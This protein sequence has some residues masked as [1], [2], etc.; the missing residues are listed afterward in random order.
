MDR[1][2]SIIGLILILV[3]SPALFAQGFSNSISGRVTGPDNRP[4]VDL[5][6]ELLDNFGRTIARKRI[7]SG[8]FYSFDGLSTGRFTV[9][10]LTSGTDFEEEEK[11]TEIYNLTP[12]MTSDEQVDFRL[13]VRQGVVKA[14]PASLFVQE[15]PAEAKSAYEKAISDLENG[16]RE[17][18][19]AGLKRAIELFPRYFHALERLGLEY[20]KR[21]NEMELR[22]A[23]ILLEAATEVNPRGYT[24][25]FGLAY[26]LNRLK[27]YDRA[28]PAAAKAVELQPQS[29]DALTLSGSILRNNHQ[30]AESEKQLLK[31][32]EL[33]DKP[34]AELHWELALLYGNHMKQYKDAAREL[35]AYLSVKPQAQNAETIKQLIA[36][37][38]SKAD[39]K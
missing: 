32:K 12:T 9:R 38:E 7:R 18:G 34:S 19:I 31:A 39:S 23:G 3:V 25:W 17:P 14:P 16:K 6:V 4:V 22:A 13:R 5:Y 21:D 15:I 1:R 24:S 36:D 33:S 30:F 26:S 10:I 20:L 8:G 29:V 37:F 28:L 11:S 35:R 27:V 2:R